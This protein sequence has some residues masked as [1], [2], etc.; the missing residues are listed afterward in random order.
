MVKQ[1]F[2]T[3][4]AIICMCNGGICHIVTMDTNFFDPM[5]KTALNLS[6]IVLNNS[7]MSEK[8]NRGQS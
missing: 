5:S 8:I 6:D 4:I 2:L 1:F 3:S 7:D